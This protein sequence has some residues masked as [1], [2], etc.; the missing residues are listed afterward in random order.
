MM[1]LN[2]IM[3]RD[4]I[5]LGP[6]AP[7]AD[8]GLLMREYRIRHI[9]IVDKKKK[10]LGLITQRDILAAAAGTDTLETTRDLMR[11]KVHTVAPESDMRA[12]GLTMQKYQIGS[13]PVVRDG[14]LIGIV[15]DSDYVALAI[16][17][18]EHI[19]INEGEEPDEYDDL[20][21]DLRDLADLS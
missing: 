19:E 13:L 8:A 2:E 17:L 15:T 1:G 12:A 11:T 7:I 5:T 3:T 16:N 20:D 21:D 6:E 18:L 14:I 10:L 9:P 4:P